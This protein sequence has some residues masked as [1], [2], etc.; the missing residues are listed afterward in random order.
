MDK[1]G[2]WLFELRMKKGMRFSEVAKELG[3]SLVFVSQVESGKK[4]LPRS[5]FREIARIYE[6]DIEEIEKHWGKDG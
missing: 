4:L 2:R 6:V 1:I 5:F 3:E